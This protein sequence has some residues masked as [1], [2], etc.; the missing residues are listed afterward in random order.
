MIEFLQNGVVDSN[1]QVLRLWYMKGDENGV[2]GR[3]A[4]TETRQDRGAGA[5]ERA[6]KAE[7]RRG[8][9]WSWS[10]DSKVRDG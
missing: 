8:S 6:P 5:R 9:D 2:G 7:K 10:F 3:I 1:A 4:E